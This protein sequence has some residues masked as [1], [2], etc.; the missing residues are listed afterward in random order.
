MADA[1]ALVDDLALAMDPVAMARACGIEPDAT[2]AALLRST[3]KRVLLNC[4]RQWGKSSITALIAL[5]EALYSAPAMII[6]ISPSQQ[7]SGELF[8]KIT[9]MWKQLPGAPAA[10]QE[11]LTRLHLSNGSRI[12]SLPGSESTTRGFSASAR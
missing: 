2:Q 3:S 12:V 11:S 6:L 4:C 9:E 7:Q 10:T 8:K 5:H 1:I